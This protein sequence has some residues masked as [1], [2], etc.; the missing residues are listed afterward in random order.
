M[1]SARS[2]TGLGDLGQNSAQGL[3]ETDPKSERVEAALPANHKCFPPLSVARSC[4]ARIF[5]ILLAFCIGHVQTV[6]RGRL[7]LQFLLHFRTGRGMVKAPDLSGP[8]A[9]NRRPGAEY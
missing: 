8:Q 4:G 7:R 3:P 6:Q 1:S 5:K 2:R 9:V